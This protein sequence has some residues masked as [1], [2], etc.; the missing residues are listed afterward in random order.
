MVTW[1]IIVIGDYL[2]LHLSELVRSSFIAATG[3]VD[4]LRSCGLETL[5]VI[6]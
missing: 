4:Q 3:S 6:I 1:L 2:V 5:E